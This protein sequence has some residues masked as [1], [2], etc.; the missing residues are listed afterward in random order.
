MIK[1]EL[2]WPF[3]FLLAFREWFSGF[4]YSRRGLALKVKRKG[5][6]GYLLFIKSMW[7]MNYLIYVSKIFQRLNIKLWVY[8]ICCFIASANS[9]SSLGIRTIGIF[10]IKIL[11][12]QSIKKSLKMLVLFDGFLFFIVKC[13][14]LNLF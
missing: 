4:Y 11:H 7:N 14:V 5:Q 10:I 6:T 8:Y 13:C 1:N 9:P 3:R 12:Q 2:V